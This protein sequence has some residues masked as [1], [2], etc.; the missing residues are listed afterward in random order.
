V[1]DYVIHAPTGLVLDF[2]QEDFGGPREAAVIARWRQR[3]K[4]DQGEFICHTHQDR[5][6]PWLYLRQHG[7][8]IVAAH[9]PGTNL[10]G[11]H[12]IV[13]GVSDEHKRQVEYIQR[14]GQDAGF[15]VATEVSH[16]TKV[17]S[18]AVIYGP[19]TTGVEV[20]RSA[21]SAQAAKARTTKA[22][23]AGVLPIWFSD[24][25]RDPKW[26]FQVPSVRMNEQPWNAV[27]RSGSVTVVSG[28]RI[29]GARR[30]RD[31]PEDRC[32][33][34]RRT[35][36][37]FCNDW[38][39]V[40]EPKLGVTVDDLAALIPAGEL[41][42]ISYRSRN[43]KVYTF[44]VDRVDKQRYE[45]VSGIPA[46]LPMLLKERLMRAGERTECAADAGAVVVREPMPTAPIHVKVRRGFCGAGVTPCGAQAQ[47]YPCG[48]RCPTHRPGAR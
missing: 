28:V 8:T 17:R 11:S 9:W 48:W 31:T 37:R 41:V 7:Q 14:A 29:I 12:E 26:L 35:G 18:D 46:D 44:I 45:D 32:P 39:P 22:R 1:R 42:P 36:R 47:L 43:G 23:R 38:H 25:A 40:H 15:E 30:C 2:G 13:H 3:G 4:A 34:S 5:E 33:N 6:K 24:A 19:T 16:H 10:N 20:Q 21:L 27:P